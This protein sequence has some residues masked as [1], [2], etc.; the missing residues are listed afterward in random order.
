[1]TSNEKEGCHKRPVGRDLIGLVCGFLKRVFAVSCSSRPVSL[2]NINFIY[3]KRLAPYII[4]YK[5]LITNIWT[6]R[7]ADYT[8][9][10][11][12]AGKWTA[13]CR[14]RAGYLQNSSYRTFIHKKIK[15]SL[16]CTFLLLSVYKKCKRL[17]RRYYDFCW[18]DVQLTN[19]AG[20][21]TNSRHFSHMT[22]IS[23]LSTKRG[24]MLR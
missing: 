24:T 21:Y 18:R 9:S 1:M 4:V 11:H 14:R 7:H 20:L 17:Q 19:P 15:F 23:C 12:W 22:Y 5:F 16:L 2:R 13:E 6:F 8:K 3:Y 10:M